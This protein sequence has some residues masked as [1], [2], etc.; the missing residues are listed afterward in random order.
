V[1]SPSTQERYANP[2]AQPHESHTANASGR[3]RFPGPDIAALF[4]S[5]GIGPGTEESR[6]KAQLHD[7][8]VKADMEAG[9]EAG[10]GKLGPYLAKLTRMVEGRPRSMIKDFHNYL[11][12][13]G[14]S[15]SYDLVKKKVQ[16]LRRGL[17]RQS[18][19]LFVSADAPF[20]QVEIH[21][22]P[23]R[24]PAGISK[25][26][27]FTMQ[28]G[29]SGRTY[30]ELVPGCELAA[31]LLCHRNAFTFF[32]GV[33]AGVFYNTREN[34]ELRRLAGGTPFHLPIVDCSRHYGYAAYPTPVFAPWMKGRLKRPGKILQKLFLPGYAFVSLEKANADMREWMARNDQ[35]WEP[36]PD[37]RPE[38]LRPLP[39]MGFDLN[40]RRQFL[41]LR[42]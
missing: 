23:L 31:F 4:A 10:R 36:N 11:R 13:E 16:A 24:G 5:G 34:T 20:A 40:E 22:I 25:A 39:E 17:G 29:L 33:P 15:G 28:L 37:S 14:Y 18:G 30:A 21:R 9:S 8:G 35:R 19:A 32:A 26:H 41:R 42:P 6:S 2:P 7:V 12:E 1:H 3:N 38:K 27:L